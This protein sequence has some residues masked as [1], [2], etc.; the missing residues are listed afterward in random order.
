MAMRTSPNSKNRGRC[1]PSPIAPTHGPQ[2]DRPQNALTISA[3]PLQ[4]YRKIYLTKGPC[5]AVF[6][7]HAIWSAG[8]PNARFAVGW[9][10]PRLRFPAERAAIHGRVKAEEEVRR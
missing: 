5:Q 1:D 8:V 2:P 9:R 7:S 10:C 6:R 3:I 4:I